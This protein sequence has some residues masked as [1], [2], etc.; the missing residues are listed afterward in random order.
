MLARKICMVGDF[1]VGKTSLVARYVHSTF[2]SEYHTTIGVKVDSKVLELP[3]GDRLKL[4]LWDIAGTSA[5]STVE[6]T[7]LRGSSGYLLVADTTRRNTLDSAISLQEKAESIIGQQPFVLLLNKID[8][9]AQ[10]ELD[11]DTVRQLK[12][13]GWESVYSSALSGQGVEEAFGRLGEHLAGMT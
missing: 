6:K 5:L 4:I 12:S 9:E 3:S 7:Y 2:S 11:L 8:L 10:C 1:A 13:R